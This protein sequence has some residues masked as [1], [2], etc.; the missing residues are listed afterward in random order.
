MLGVRFRGST[1]KLLTTSP[2]DLRR[3][4]ALLRRG[5]LVAFPTETVYGLG[6]RADDPHAVA[7]I[8]EAKRR[9]ADHPLIVHLG[10]PNALERWARDVPESAHRLASRFWP[11]PLTIVLRRAD[12]V[13]SLVTGGQPT[14]ALRLP[15]H[16]VALALLAEV[17]SGLAAPSANRFGRI[18][19]TMASHVV[20]EL[21]DCVDAVVD[22]GP[23]RVGLESTIVDLSGIHPRILRPGVI[24]AEALAE[25]LGTRLED[26]G[27]DAPRAPGMLATHYA[28]VTPIELLDGE[29]LEAR[30]HAILSEGEGVVAVLAF[31]PARVD[32]PRC[33][34]RTMPEDA[35]GYAHA[36]YAALR[37]ADRP[38]CDV[39]L[40]ER[41]PQGASW[42]A[43]YDRLKRAAT[44]D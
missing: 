19:P 44:R 6:A 25:A 21:G 37:E 18:S 33:R 36:L 35:A 39:I 28:P 40:V 31:G 20:D 34:W 30:A 17:G 11:G 42:V 41:P 3:A 24:T 15:N 23:C 26:V 2:D 8:F 1:M 22:G 32:T 9:P 14:I 10:D 27:D 38:D 7:R 16:P 43:V 29:D 12:S 4:G 5:G 13:S